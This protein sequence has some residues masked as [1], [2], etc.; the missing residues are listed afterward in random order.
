MLLGT[1]GFV[2]HECEETGCLTSV[3]VIISWG[4]RAPAS[5]VGGGES[6]VGIRPKSC[7]GAA[8]EGKYASREGRSERTTERL[9]PS[10]YGVG[11]ELATGVLRRLWRELM[12][13]SVRSNHP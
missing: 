9:A 4:S 6:I 11:K 3:S 1:L 2:A 5:M 8:E 10:R 7:L 13:S 12:E